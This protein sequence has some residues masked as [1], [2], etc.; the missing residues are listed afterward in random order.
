MKNLKEAVS[1]HIEDEELKEYGLRERPSILA[2]TE[3]E[4]HAVA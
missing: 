2:M 3:L 1:L 4:L